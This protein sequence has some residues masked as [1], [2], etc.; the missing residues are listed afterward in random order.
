MAPASTDQMVRYGVIFGGG[1]II[2]NMALQG[3][4]GPSAL[5]T[6]T[7]IQEAIKGTKS[8]QT[9][10]PNPQSQTPAPQ[11]TATNPT[12]D[13]FSGTGANFRDAL[14]PN[15]YQQMIDWQNLR[16]A[17]GE[18]PHNWD[19]FVTHLSHIGAPNPGTIAPPGL[20][21]YALG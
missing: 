15:L 17:R 20:L 13:R 14:N 9:P 1:W 19:A 5:K 11:T 18:D 7:D 3:K 16:R 10:T 4:L 2:Y 6:A 21:F 12:G 8:Q